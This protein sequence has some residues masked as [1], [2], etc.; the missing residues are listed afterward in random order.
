MSPTPARLLAGLALVALLAGGVWAVASEG[1]W[2]KGRMTVRPNAKSAIGEARG[3]GTLGGYLGQL[4]RLLDEVRPRNYGVVVL[5]TFDGANPFVGLASQRL[6]PT[7]VVPAYP[8][9][10]EAVAAETGAAA[11]LRSS[12]GRDWVC[13]ELA[14]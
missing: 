3:G 12:Q 2:A 8:K 6:F 9:E 13:E 4:D 1:P 14:P 11:V 5:Q 10:V 7:L